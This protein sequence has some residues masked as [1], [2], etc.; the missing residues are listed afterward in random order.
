M[1]TVT[2]SRTLTTQMMDNRLRGRYEIS[3][4]NGQTW[5]AICVGEGDATSTGWQVTQ[6]FRTGNAVSGADYDDLSGEKLRREVLIEGGRYRSSPFDNGHEFS[7]QKMSF[8][9]FKGTGHVLLL[10]TG[11]TRYRYVG[12]I[13]TYNTALTG[14]ASIPT[15]D[16]NLVRMWGAEAVARTLPALPEAG[17]TQLI[18]ELR[19][20]G[21]PNVLGWSLTHRTVNRRLDVGG[22]FLNWEFGWKPIWN[23]LKNIMRS[24]K[25]ANRLTRQYY[26]DSGQQVRRKCTV[27]KTKTTTVVGQNYWVNAVAAPGTGGWSLSLFTVGGNSVRC[28]LIEEQERTVSFSGAYTYLAIGHEAKLARIRQFEERANLLLGTRF[29][30]STAWNLTS[31]TWLFDW[32]A[33][34][35]TILSN[36]NALSSDG[37]VMRYGY[38]MVDTKTTRKLYPQTPLQLW[39]GGTLIPRGATCTL[40]RKERFR[41]NPFGFGL[42]WSLLTERQLAIL[43]ALGLSKS[44]DIQL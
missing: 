42:D 33:D 31:W 34:I 40:H 18:A 27:E 38:V 4:D 35:G 7:T 1:P 15:T 5:S 8:A 28:S 14:M 12:G 23:D 41:A 11:Q 25:N 36:A 39:S 2:Q 10:G 9:P 43:V 37:R 20:E 44:G 32:W 24:L 3:R 29:D 22:Q 30:A 17:L 16:L 26:R 13:A 21:L 19:R 6:S